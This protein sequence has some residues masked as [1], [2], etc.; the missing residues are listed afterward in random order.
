MYL[1]LYIITYLGKYLLNLKPKK[2]D[3]IRNQ[4]IQNH[5]YLPTRTCNSLRKR[6]RENHNT[7]T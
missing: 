1:G 2:L 6:E 7:N 3:I 5:K 4:P